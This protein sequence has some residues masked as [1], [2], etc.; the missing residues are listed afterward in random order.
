MEPVEERVS[1]VLDR[2]LVRPVPPDAD[3]DDPDELA[4]WLDAEDQHVAAKAVAALEGRERV[5]TA[6]HYFEYLS[7]DEI[8]TLFRERRDAVASI[9]HR[10]RSELARNRELARRYTSEQKQVRWRR[11]ISPDERDAR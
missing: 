6:L 1:R 9:C 3:S 8:A 2:C 7:L 5:I 11:R 10:A 4:A